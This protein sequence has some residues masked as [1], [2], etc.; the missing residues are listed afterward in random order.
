M[1]DIFSRV[2]RSAVMSRIRSHGNESTEN[3]LAKLFRR[4]QINGWRRQMEVRSGNFETKFKVK[5]DFIF[6]KRKLAVF[7][8]GC[9]WHSCPTHGHQPE[10]NRKFWKSKFARNQARDRF[11]NRKLRNLGWRVIR[12]WE[13]RLRKNPQSCVN[14]ILRALH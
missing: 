13:C 10:G 4:H 11:V 1:A 3:S 12:I 7:V 6:W 2:K 14:R 9:F 5:P 8:D